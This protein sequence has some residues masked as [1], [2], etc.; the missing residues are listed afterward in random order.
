VKA[1]AVASGVVAFG[2]VLIVHSVPCRAE[3]TDASGQSSAKSFDAGC[4]LARAAQTPLT[5][6]GLPIRSFGLG[7]ATSSSTAGGFVAAAPP[8]LLPDNHGQLWLG[9]L[10]AGPTL[11]DGSSAT[12]ASSSSGRT[13]RYFVPSWM[14]KDALAEFTGPPPLE[15]RGNGLGEAVARGAL[16]FLLGRAVNQLNGSQGQNRLVS[17]RSAS[18]PHGRGVGLGVSAAW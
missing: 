12:F 5:L 14:P 10:L 3:E 7:P 15:K 17:V 16:G 8:P 9:S 4:V 6:G 1:L 11:N 13:K 18:D 2:I